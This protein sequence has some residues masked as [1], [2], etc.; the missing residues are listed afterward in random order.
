MAH[1]EQRRNNANPGNN[2]TVKDYTKL[3]FCQNSIK[4]KK[5]IFLILPLAVNAVLQI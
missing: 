5:K 4:I 2:M 1:D 3:F